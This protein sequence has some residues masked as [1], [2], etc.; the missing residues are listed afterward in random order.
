[1][2]SGARE[3]RIDVMDRVYGK[4]LGQVR[5]YLVNLKR[6]EAL[7]NDPTEQGRRGREAYAFKLAGLGVGMPNH[8]DRFCPW[9]LRISVCSSI[10]LLVLCWNA[11]A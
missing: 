2:H 10:L 3:T 6:L 7:V 8:P 4:M 9:A 1:M 5:M 11:F